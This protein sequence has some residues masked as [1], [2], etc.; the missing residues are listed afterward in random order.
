[1]P[2]PPLRRGRMVSPLLVTCA[3]PQCQDV[4]LSSGHSVFVLVSTCC[5]SR[6]K[7]LFTSIFLCSENNV[8][9][10][11]IAREWEQLYSSLSKPIA[12]SLNSLSILQLSTGLYVQTD[13]F[14][15][16]FRRLRPKH[17]GVLWGR[18]VPMR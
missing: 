6:I 15:G 9:L 5:V 1:M 3:L 14:G 11:Q 4:K 8:L 7:S 2:P 18:G 16:K 17:T 13:R 12:F 10:L